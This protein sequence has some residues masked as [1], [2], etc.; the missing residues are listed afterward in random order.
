MLIATPPMRVMFS[1]ESPDGF[2]MSTAEPFQVEGQEE[3][4]VIQSLGVRMPVA[5]PA[6]PLHTVALLESASTSELNFIPL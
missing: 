2:K 3:C 4:V 1:C 6:A 5:D